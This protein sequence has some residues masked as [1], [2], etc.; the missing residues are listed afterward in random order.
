MDESSS[1]EK[2]KNRLLCFQNSIKERKQM[3]VVEGN[4]ES[5]TFTIDLTAYAEG[6]GP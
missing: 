1:S 6:K 3:L 5:K 2:K 4:I